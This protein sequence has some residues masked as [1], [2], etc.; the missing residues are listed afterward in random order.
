[1]NL[2]AA[3]IKQI[4]P[5]TFVQAISQV[6]D[7]MYMN[8]KRP[9]IQKNSSPKPQESKLFWEQTRPSQL[10]KGLGG[11]LDPNLSCQYCRDTWHESENY[12]HLECHL[13][14]DRM[15][16]EGVVAQEA[17]NAEHYYL[18]AQLRV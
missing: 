14:R 4:D 7:C 5:Q 6:M 18:R 17:A 12:W 8:I 2:K 10:A 3:Q 15:A 13:I 1:M 11:S 16:T 9:T